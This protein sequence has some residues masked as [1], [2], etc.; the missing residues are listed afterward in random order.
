MSL[1]NVTLPTIN[2]TELFPDVNFDEIV[3]EGFSPIKGVKWKDILDGDVTLNGE[4]V[5]YLFNDTEFAE[6]EVPI[7]AILDQV[8]N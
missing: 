4:Q 3:E 1:I 5:L 6:V 8:L 2:A 7:D